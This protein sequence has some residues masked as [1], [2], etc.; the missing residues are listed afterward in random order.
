M[1]IAII[2]GTGQMGRWFTKFFLDQGASVIISGR[3]PEKLLKIGD[4][5]GVEIADNVNAVKGADRVLICV[6]IESFEDVV[7]EIHSSVEPNQIVMDICSIKEMPVDTMHKYLG[8]AVTL[9]THPMFGPSAE[10]LENQN[11]VL[12]PTNDR[13]RQ[14]AKD[15]QHWL[16][17][18]KARVSIMSPK[19]HDELMSVVLGFAHF[20]GAV[21]C[22]TLLSQ[23]DFAEIKKVAGPSYKTLLKLAEG[24]TSQDPNFYASLQMNLPK[25]HE[26]E[27]LFYEKGGEWLN[28][29]KKKDELFLANKMKSIR[30]KLEGYES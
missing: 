21:V 7:K 24:V 11:F 30:K 10:S 1:R 14:L 22:D 29:I 16:E 19:K 17:E 6:S 4:E 23:S 9:G 13:E 27:S 25:V 12:T 26:I 3:N 15:F 18:K 5:L 8:E 20:V 2:G 28:I